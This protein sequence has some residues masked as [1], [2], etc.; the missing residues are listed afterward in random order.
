M[1]IK[2]RLPKNKFQLH[3]WKLYWTASSAAPCFFGGAVDKI[4]TK[5]KYTP[6]IFQLPDPK[7]FLG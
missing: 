6:K 1:R 3:Y 5:K 2:A 7:T 4:F